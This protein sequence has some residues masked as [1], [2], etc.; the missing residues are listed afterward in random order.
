[1]AS[2]KQFWILISIIAL[3]AAS[4][5]GASGACSTCGCGAG[6]DQDAWMKEAK[7]FVAGEPVNDSSSKIESQVKTESLPKAETLAEVEAP[8]KTE[9]SPEA[10][11]PASAMA[12]KIRS[13]SA[14]AMLVP[15]SEAGSAEILL[16][17]DDDPAEYI[18]GAIH[19]SY[20]S[21]ED[22]SGLLKPV[23]E[24]VKVLG[25][26]GINERNEVVICG[27]CS[28]QA[29]QSIATYVYWIMK[30][31]GHEKVR[32]LDGGVDDWVAMKQP[33]VSEPKVLP[34]TTYAS[35]LNPKLLSSYDYVKNGPATIVDARTA[36]EFEVESITNA[37]NIPFEEVMKDGEIK[38]EAALKVLFKDLD[39]TPP[40]V[41][42]TDTGVT[43]TVSWFALKLLGY[44]ARL[45]TWA[46]WTAHQPGIYLKDIHA[47]PNPAR[48]G[49]IV[50]ITATFS[51]RTSQEPSESDEAG[52]GETVLT[53]MQCTVCG[54]G[55]TPQG[56]A[57]ITQENNTTGSVK[58]GGPATSSSAG[59]FNDTMTCMATITDSSG[60]LAGKAILKRVSSDE[61]SGIW[62]AN[63]GQGVY[64]VTLDLTTPSGSKV[65]RD[66]LEIEVMGL[67]SKYKNLEK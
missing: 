51:S 50:K 31:L 63:V 65:F 25:D 38:D 14:S 37:I 67:T 45:Y 30:Y 11:A 66:A 53:V 42:Y 35:N 48:T 28:C 9:S 29:G 59:F 15:V 21:F 49:D 16:D 3:A 26:A 47:D 41:V 8:A 43:A 10:G 33:T 12:S 23:P 1:M 61:F 34:K 60:K 18:P 27:K 62:N 24:L 64:K 46:D 52:N 20:M 40:V 57:I 55:F 5:G 39:K 22:K 58:I 36:K 4:I 19:I 32:I 54:G 56:Y 2:F 44:D 7:S 17:V 13:K 6:A